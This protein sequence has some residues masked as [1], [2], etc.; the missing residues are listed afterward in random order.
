[1]DE[2]DIQFRVSR[3]V[4]EK[5]ELVVVTLCEQIVGEQNHQRLVRCHLRRV[6]LE[7]LKTLVDE[8]LLNFLHKIKWNEVRDEGKILPE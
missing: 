2:A 6:S 3:P 7:Q 4:Q 1:M 5:Q 8:V